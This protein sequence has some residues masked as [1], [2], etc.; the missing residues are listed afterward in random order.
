MIEPLTES[1]ALASRLD[2]LRAR[3]RA[4]E[5]HAG[6]PPGSIELL[7]VS[8]TF[9]AA[10]IAALHAHGQRSFGENYVQEALVKIAELAPRYIEW[11]FIGRIQSNKTRVIAE[12]FT[13]AHGLD[14]LAI[15]QRLNDQRP[16]DAAP[17]DVC[18]EVNV[19]NESSKAGVSLAALPE[20]AHAITSLPRLRLRGLMV[21]PAPTADFGLQQAAFARA[22]TALNDL[23][24][25]GLTLDTLS[26]GTSGDLEAAVAA[27]ATIVRIGTALFGPR[28]SAR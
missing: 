11:H 2:A 19:D 16:A 3:I 20:L 5:V 25:Q 10:A 14:R 13:W 21:L 27:G 8:K 26:M 17:L 18:I 9:P 12:Y 23:R 28:E 15:A 6:R 24:R 4:A 1:L 22:Q 7:A